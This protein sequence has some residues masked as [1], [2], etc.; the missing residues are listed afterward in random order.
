MVWAV[1]LS[2]TK[3]IPRC[4]TPGLW[5]N[6]IRSLVGVGKFSPP[7]PSRALPPLTIPEA[8]PQC[9][10]GRTSYLRVRLAYHPYPQ[11]IR[12]LCNV[13]QFG[14]PLRFYRSF[15]LAMDSSPGFGSDPCD[16]I[17]P[18]QTC[19]RYGSVTNVT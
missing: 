18:I 2:T 16:Y 4:L 13:D 15:T 17:R 12:Q 6:G 19:F 11:L 7:S 1:S 3:L 5:V 9:I 8:A 10:S 14:P